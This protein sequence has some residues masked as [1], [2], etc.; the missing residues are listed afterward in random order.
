M[1]PSSQ[2]LFW[3]IHVFW[4][5]H[6]GCSCGDW[7]VRLGY[8]FDFYPHTVLGV[9]C[10]GHILDRQLRSL[11][12]PFALPQK[13]AT[14]TETKRTHG[15]LPAP[16]KVVCFSLEAL[17]N[18]AWACARRLLCC[19]PV[20][21]AGLGVWGAS[22]AYLLHICCKRFGVVWQLFAVLVFVLYLVFL[23]LALH[24]LSCLVD[25]LFAGLLPFYLSF[26]H[27]TLGRG[28]STQGS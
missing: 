19:A 22:V 23:L 14:A 4:S 9:A 28:C 18:V 12:F 5:G 7:D 13:P 10:K 21:E 15:Q 16:R 25:C 2:R 11:F 1:L 8:D 20:M 6:G 26:W 3:Q 17:S 24:C 27:L